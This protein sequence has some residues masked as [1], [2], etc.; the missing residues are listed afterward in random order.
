MNIYNRR[1][2]GSK[3]KI[4]DWIISLITKHCIGNR[5][6]EVFAGT[7]IISSKIAQKMQTVILNDTLY[8][9]NIIYKAFYS[10]GDFDFYKLYN[11]KDKLNYTKTIGYFSKNYGNKYFSLNDCIKIEH[12]RNLI[13]NEKNNFT[14]KE[15]AIL[16]ASL[17]YSMDKCANTVGHF[18]SYRQGVLLHDR[19]EFNF[20][21]PFEFDTEFQIYKKDANEL[22]REVS[23]DIA[24]IDPL[25]NSRQYCQFYHIYET[26]VHWN[27][28][29]LFGTA[30]KPKSELLSDYCRVKAPIV[31]E[32]LI[33]N[34]NSR[35]IVVSYNN[36]YKS[37]SSSSKNKITLEEIETI[38]NKKGEVK[39]FQTEHKFFNAGKTAFSDHKEIL[40]I[41]KI[42]E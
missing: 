9:N 33:K 30:L 40:F 11:F 2:T 15:Y 20:I 4:S 12:I 42:Y 10:K 41:V 29:E 14:L 26:I 35:F 28:P 25:Y 1:Y 16:I 23:S 31:F 3:L 24:Y 7:S 37:K 5:F 27:N 19:F 38:L 17:I 8:A 32:D 34:I 22:V 6:F 21:K 13:E 39:I 36:T 18:D